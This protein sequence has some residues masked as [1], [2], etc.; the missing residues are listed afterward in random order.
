MNDEIHERLDDLRQRI[1]RACVRGGRRPGG[2]ELLAVSKTFDTQRV[3]AALRAGQSGFGENYTQEA[4]PK[5][6]ALAAAGERPVWH[7]IG[8]MQS[9]KTRAVA[10]HFSWAHTVGRLKIAERL[11]AQRPAGLPALDVCVQV[12]ISAEDSKSGCAPEAAAELCTAVA[13][14]PRLRLRGLMA[15]P[16][17]TA[18]PEAMRPAF[19]ALRALFAQIRDAGRID[20]AC[21]DT[22]SMGMSDDFEIAI[23]EGATIVRIGSALFGR[24]PAK[25]PGAQ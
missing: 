20:T 5:I 10:E 18:E 24:R 9:N 13:Q 22:L 17:P 3:L 14:L 19:R 25:P 12:N 4:L 2:V 23:E 11:S 16:A 15:I 8:P 6:E 7:F 1:T 21:F